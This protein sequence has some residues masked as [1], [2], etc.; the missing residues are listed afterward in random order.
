MTPPLVRRDAR[1]TPRRR[2]IA[3]M[4]LSLA[5]WGL[6]AQAGASPLAL[7]TDAERAA[8]VARLREYRDA[9]RVRWVIAAPDRADALAERA[10]VEQDLSPDEKDLATRI[11]FPNSSA[12]LI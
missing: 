9:S 12:S 2:G 7:D 6:A 5:A 11:R 4:V 10:R 8:F 1:V 3:T